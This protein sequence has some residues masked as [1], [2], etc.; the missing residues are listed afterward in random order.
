MSLPDSEAAGLAPEQLAAR[1]KTLESQIRT[2]TSWWWS[3]AGFSLV[4]TVL[5][6]VGSEYVFCVGLLFTEFSDYGATKYAHEAGAAA[7]PWVI[8]AS[9]VFDALLIGGFTLVARSCDR[10]RAWVVLAGLVIYALDTALLTTSGITVSLF[11]HGLTLWYGFRAFRAIG[12]LQRLPLPEPALAATPAPSV[13]APLPST[14]ALLPARVPAVP[15]TV[16]ASVPLAPPLRSSLEPALPSAAALVPPALPSSVRPPSRGI[17]I[18]PRTEASVEE[19]EE[20][21]PRSGLNPQ[22][23]GLPALIVGLLV[24]GFVAVCLIY[25]CQEADSTVARYR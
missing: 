22:F 4:N 17:V 21:A 1:R 14:P 5:V 20:S 15:Q 7:N 19:P 13:P 2:G 10:R 9:Y 16:P 6:R 3:V 18:Q 8:V 24:L 11:V 23:T 25:I 12:Q